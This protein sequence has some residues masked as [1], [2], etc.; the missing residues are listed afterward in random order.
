M[1]EEHFISSAS[2][3]NA[4]LLKKNLHDKNLNKRYQNLKTN[5]SQKIKF[6]SNSSILVH[7]ENSLY[8]L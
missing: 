4:I 7:N 3:L 1:K 5:K 6:Y 8:I 2:R